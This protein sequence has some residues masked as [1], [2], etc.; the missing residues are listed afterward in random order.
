[1]VGW[2]G[3][4]GSRS[5]WCFDTSKVPDD[6]SAWRVCAPGDILGDTEEFAQIGLPRFQVNEQT[7]KLT[8]NAVADGIDEMLGTLNIQLCPDGVAS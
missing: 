2:P 5:S 1:M 4:P 8:W 7:D 6:K 3:F